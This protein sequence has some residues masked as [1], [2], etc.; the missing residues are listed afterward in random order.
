MKPVIILDDLGGGVSIAAIGARACT[1]EE[2]NALISL[3]AGPVR[4][5]VTPQRADQFQLE[6]MNNRRTIGSGDSPSG[7]YSAA[8][9]R[10]PVDLVSV[11]A[12]NGVHSG[13]SVSDRATTVAILGMKGPSP[14]ELVSPG[15]VFPRLGA[16]GGLLERA[17]A[18][19]GSLTVF[20]DENSDDD[21]AVACVELLNDAGEPATTD[22]VCALA[23]TAGLT[24]NSLTDLVRS[25]LTSSPLITKIAES[26]LPIENL[27]TFKAV[28]FM[29]SVGKREHLALVRGEANDTEAPTVR[30]HRKKLLEDV[31]GVASA[32]GPHIDKLRLGLQRVAAAQYGVFLYLDTVMGKGKFEPM[33][34]YA[35]GAQILVNLG[36]T[37]AKIITDSPNTVTGSTIFGVTIE[38]QESLSPAIR[39]EHPELT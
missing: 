36:I 26:S 32:S 2:L 30:V 18:Y 34:D 27:G 16:A 28:L 39:V 21:I 17:D 3:G 6:A 9:N 4:V 33:R 12:R 38:A 1:S 10:G 29:D 15:H 31:F 13:I 11:E 25:K 20:E 37:K 5:I 35:I 8:N 14:R 7:N 22:E 24:V 23:R 19:Q